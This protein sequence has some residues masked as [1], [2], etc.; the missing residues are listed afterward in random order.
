MFGVVRGVGGVPLEIEGLWGKDKNYSTLPFSDMKRVTEANRGL[1]IDKH[2]GGRE[3]LH[4]TEEQAMEVIRVRRE[5]L[6]HI[7]EQ[8]E[9]GA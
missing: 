5:Y 2:S 7:K 8:S 6:E 3:L 9:V 1:Y 4:C